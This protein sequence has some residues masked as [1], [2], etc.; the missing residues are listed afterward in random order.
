MLAKLYALLTSWTRGSSTTYT[1]AEDVVYIDSAGRVV[2]HRQTWT[3]ERLT[4]L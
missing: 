1:S 2:A 3:T 4:I